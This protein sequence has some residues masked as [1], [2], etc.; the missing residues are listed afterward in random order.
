MRETLD[1][2]RARSLPPGR[3]GPAAN[4]S[5]AAAGPRRIPLW[6]ILVATIALQAVVVTFGLRAL[7]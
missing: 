2:G 5:H 3:A 6:T 7:S 4:P 1:T